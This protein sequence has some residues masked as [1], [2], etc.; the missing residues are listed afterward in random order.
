VRFRV[1]GPVQAS[2]DN[3]AAVQ[4]PPKPRALL[5][6][7]LL[8]AGRPVSRERLMAA[9]WRE[10]PPASAPRV[11][12]T[13]VSTL[14]QALRLS[15]G[16]RLPRLVPLGD[17]YRL[18]TEPADLDLLVF[19][20][21]AERGRRALG[22]GDA[23][24][25]ARLLDQALGLWRG[26]PAEDVSVD[27]DTGVLLAGLV[28][29]RLLAE[30]DRTEAELV[31]GHDAALIA[32]LRHLLSAHPLRERLWGQLMTALYRTG[33]QA[34]ALDAYQQVRTR[35]VAELGVEPGPALREL[36]QQILAGDSLPAQYLA[37]RPTAPVV[38]RQVPLDVSRFT[39][40]ASELTLLDALIHPPGADLP[41]PV[42][43][44]V[45]TGTAGVGKTALAIHW[46][47]RVADRF[48][49]GQLYASLRGHSPARAVNPLEVLAGFLRAMG[50][51]A[52]HI[53]GDLDEAAAMYRSLLRGRRFLIVLDNAASSEQVRPLLPAAPG[54]AVVVTSR[55]RLP[56]LTARDGAARISLGPL[57]PAEAVAL[58]RGIL[59]A[60]RAEAEL[61]AVADIAA[62]C[63]FL[64]LALRIAADR[65]TARPCQ[66]LA[67]LADQLA[68]ADDRLD[69]LTSADDPSTSVRP[70]FSWSY[71]A[72]PVD[73]K[74]M[75]RLAALPTGPDISVPAAA[76]LAATSHAEARSLLEALAGTHLVEEHTPGRYR[77]HDLLRI[78]A[79]EVA[80]ADESD[81]ARATAIHRVLTW[82]LHTAEAANRR[83]EPARRP[84][85]L[86]TAPPRCQPLPFATYQQA[87]SWCDAE[88]ENLIAAIRQA[89][90]AGH[91]DIGWKLP[92]T[93]FMY[94]TLRRRW[95]D[96]RATMTIAVTCAIR[97]GDQHGVA[98]TTDCLGH[99]YLQLRHHEEALRCY[100]LT[101]STHRQI[102][103][104]RGE[105]A[106][107]NN[108][109]CSYEVTGQ[110]AY[111]AR[112]YE[113]A[114]AIA[115]DSGNRY[116]EA[117]ALS[118][119]GEAYHHLGQL[120][121][122][123]DSYTRSLTIIR[124]TGGPQKEGQALHQ[125]AAALLAA[126]QYEQA[127]EAYREALVVRR[128]AGDRHGEAETL[129]AAGDLLQH[130]GRAA[131]AHACWLRALAAFEELGD[132][133]ADELR[134]RLKTPVA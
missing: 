119:L 56:G 74:Q 107:L 85:P 26:E 130:L 13:Y 84:T 72:Q 43:I 22:E 96:L 21:L 83:L 16:D 109:G 20:D 70:V 108:L 3:G 61:S 49:D 103:D 76:A 71:R 6:V 36:H 123:L 33:Q 8:N 93:L 28:E 17:G 65:A 23:V 45:V 90:A 75:F 104:R 111:A 100:R 120:S 79:A 88:H 15:R 91:D 118:N 5:A 18:E 55:D 89:A 42:A 69:M 78:Y 38:P 52:G 32:R 115:R 112:C 87:L 9:L 101:L 68:A 60:R 124:E 14:R 10:A 47:H 66:S 122:S 29:R 59:G 11:I 67:V 92:V 127:E 116:G 40:R 54:C 35:L 30:E 102:G 133:Q 1:I 113:Q 134:A 48:P 110:H 46:A 77:F 63:E 34:A 132:P 95:A 86:G 131:N 25:A 2:A 126:G 62:R 128:Q 44:A 4:L 80:G 57:P 129:R 73:A 19:D 106:A 105:C 37:A 98:W 81:A 117:I 125:L 121:A 50:A 58:L 41:A 64:P 114:L 99:A 12:R 31:L 39:G 51:V 27:E 53:P 24:V 7:L 97:C 82:Y 94:F